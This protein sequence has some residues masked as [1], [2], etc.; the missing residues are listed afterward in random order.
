MVTKDYFTE[1]EKKN[2]V[3][4]SAFPVLLYIPEGSVQLLSLFRLSIYFVFH[5]L[6][7]IFIRYFLHLNFKCYPLS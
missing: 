6:I 7:F 2:Q 5:L 3:V 4:A 1:F